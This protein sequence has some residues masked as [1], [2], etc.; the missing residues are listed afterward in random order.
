M[1]FQQDSDACGR[2]VRASS[3][4]QALASRRDA[5]A[6]HLADRIE[7]GVAA[8]IW[9]RSEADGT[10]RKRAR[11]LAPVTDRQ[12]IEVAEKIETYLARNHASVVPL[13]QRA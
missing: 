5:R 9:R 10:P 7:E 2:L 11:P 6:R 3:A 12:L 13:R 8:L 4:L 1:A